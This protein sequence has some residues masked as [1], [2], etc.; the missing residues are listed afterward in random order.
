MENMPALQ[1]MGSASIHGT[2]SLT[3]R[4]NDVQCCLHG[5][6]IIIVGNDDLEPKLSPIPLPCAKVLGNSCAASVKSVACCLLNP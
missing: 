1:V 6:F 2:L 4:C 5:T 3:A